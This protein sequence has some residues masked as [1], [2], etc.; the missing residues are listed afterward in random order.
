[1]KL[2]QNQI[3]K[4]TDSLYLRIVNLERLAVDYKAM[5]DLQTREGTHQRVTKKEFCR[6]LKGAELWTAPQ[7]Q[8]PVD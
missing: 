5:K 3:W 8:A 6:M 4:T 7:K 1:M 2:Q